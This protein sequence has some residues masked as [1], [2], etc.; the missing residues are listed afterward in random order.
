[1]EEGEESG[2]GGGQNLHDDGLRVENKGKGN[3]LHTMW[4]RKLLDYRIRRHRK[5]TILSPGA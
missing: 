4:E 3:A 2:M 5:P 1:V